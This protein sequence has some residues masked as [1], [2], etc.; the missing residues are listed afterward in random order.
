M[1]LRPKP[2]HLSVGLDAHAAILEAG[3]HCEVNGVGELL[4][5][6]THGSALSAP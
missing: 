4:G 2:G 1:P 6:S 3:V 5:C